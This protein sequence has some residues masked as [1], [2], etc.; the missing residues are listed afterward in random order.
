MPR[1]P[2]NFRSTAVKPFYREEI[3]DEDKPDEGNQE[4]QDPN[5]THEPGSPAK[6]GQEQP[7][8]KPRGR[9]PRSRNKPREEQPIRRSNR[10][11]IA[12][13]F[14]TAVTNE[15]EAFMVFMTRKEQ[16]DMEL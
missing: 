5:P 2:A 11:I 4:H 16:A 9:P 15:E 10:N 6:Q 14:I 12:D 8:Y 3:P 7:Q 13:Q 1:G